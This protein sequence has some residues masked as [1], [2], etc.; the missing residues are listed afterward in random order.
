MC[1]N[2][3]GFSKME[4]IIR[5]MGMF[6]GIIVFFLLM[7]FAMTSYAGDGSVKIASVDRGLYLQKNNEI[8]PPVVSEQY[9]YYI[10]KGD[11]QEALRCEMTKNGCKWNDGKKYDSVTTWRVKW[12]YDYDRGPQTCR[13][14][15]FQATVDITF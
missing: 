8:V 15:S 12:H 6:R 10:V 2:G 11:N 5:S 7:T 9:E 14:E 13:A 1:A 4:T 3:N